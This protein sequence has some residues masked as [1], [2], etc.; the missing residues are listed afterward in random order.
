MT[1]Q[2]WLVCLVGASAL[3]GTTNLLPQ[4]AAGPCSKDQPCFQP[5]IDGDLYP[6]EFADGR[7]APLQDYVSG[8]PNGTLHFMVSD[9]A[10]FQAD[11]CNVT[12]PPGSSAGSPDPCANQS[13]VLGL[14]VPRTRGVGGQF[15]PFRGSVTILLDTRRGDT[16]AQFSAALKPRAEDRRITIV[17]DDAAGTQSVA[18]AHGNGV[19]WS[20]A[21]SATEFPVIAKVATHGTDPFADIEVRIR[22]RT[23]AGTSEPL[24]T[25][26]RKLGLAVMLRPAAG[27]VPQPGM[28]AN[29][30]N[31]PNASPS[32]LSPLAWETLD[33]K[34]LKP[35]PFSMSVWNVGQMTTIGPDDGGSGEIDTIAKAIYR[36]KA[37]CLT[38][39][40]EA[41]ERVEIVEEVNALRA[42]E[43]LPAIYSLTDDDDEVLEVGGYTGLVMLSENPIV[44]GGVHHFKRSDCT[45]FDCWQNKGVIWAR[46]QTVVDPPPSVGAVPIPH[47]ASYGEFVD[48]FCTHVNAGDNGYGPDT[49]VRE[50]QFD[51][52]RAYIAQVRAGGPLDVASYPYQPGEGDLFPAG[53]WPSGLDRPA[54]LLGDLNTLGP[55]DATKDDGFPHY[56][57]MMDTHFKVRGLSF[58]ERANSLVSPAR[59]L[60][61]VVSGADPTMTGTW[62][63][64]PVNNTIQSELNKKDRLD[65]VIVFPPE[66]GISAPTFALQSSSASVDAHFDPDSAFPVSPTEVGWQ[67]LSD[68]AELLVDVTL[69]RLADVLKYNPSKP[70]RFEYA[71]KTVTDLETESGCCADWYSPLVRLEVNGTAYARPYLTVMEGST[72]HPNWK[73]ETGSGIPDLPANYAG[74]AR[75][76]SRVMEAD[77]WGDD[78]Y[79]SIWEGGSSTANDNRDAHFRF[80]AATGDV[81]R[82]K[83]SSP[84][85]DWNVNVDWLG[86]FLTGFEEGMTINTE[87]NDQ[88]TNNNARVRHYISVTE[89][90]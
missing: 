88:D 69:V 24:S 6:L 71:V 58:F 53:K 48:L 83:G 74:S 20:A 61:R 17:F 27:A 66:S 47:A 54:F 45:G 19:G 85:S 75:A 46:V 37:I 67:C 40:W 29:F 4:D 18:Q 7:S 76:S 14:H 3:A 23:N 86:S 64:S 11:E 51:D 49:D 56:V 77:T 60:G 8:G 68:H 32:D 30:P 41:G 78:H 42:A 21:T 50:N 90:Q 62:L 12:V 80:D 72:I 84:S 70:H 31:V 1:R 25:T 79:D 57:A 82:V 63:G 10:A 16:L 13:L 38:E 35:I 22:L 34:G 5:S 59:D 33:L 81:F 73:I 55:R 43:G 9:V 28:T 2:L 44:E 87:G 65:Y 26:S 89:L 39:I 52:L 15:L 36:R